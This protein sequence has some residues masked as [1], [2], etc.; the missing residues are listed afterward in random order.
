MLRAKFA[1]LLA[2]VALV[3]LQQRAHK[4]EV[5]RIAH[6]LVRQVLRTAL[7]FRDSL[8]GDRVIA[9]IRW[10]VAFDE[11][12]LERCRRSRRIR[13]W[14]SGRIL[15]TTRRVKADAVCLEFVLA[16]EI[17]LLVA[18]RAPA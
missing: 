2:R 12:W 4:M 3:A 17:D 15:P 6:L 13:P 8:V 7:R 9:Q 18:R 11:S 5:Q 16:R 14:R 10:H 1:R